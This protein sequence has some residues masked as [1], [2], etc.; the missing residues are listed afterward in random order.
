MKKTNDS[1]TGMEEML[2]VKDVQNHLGIC[3]EKAYKLVQ[4]K[5]FP[6]MKIGN[7]YVIPKSE[8]QKW[9]AKNTYRDIHLK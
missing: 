9:I 2:T 8:Y 1:L 3:R 6:R 4:L 5:S 7:R